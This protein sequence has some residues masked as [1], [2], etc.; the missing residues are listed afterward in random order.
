MPQDPVLQL[1]E[2]HAEEILQ[3]GRRERV[4]PSLRKTLKVL[5]RYPRTVCVIMGGGVIACVFYWLIAPREYEARSTVALRT[6]RVN[7]LHL[8]GGDEGAISAASGP[9]QLETLAGVFRS[10]QLA[11]RVILERHL[12]QAWA[13]NGDFAR[14]F[15]DFHPEAVHPSAQGFLLERFQQR[16]MVRTIPR[17]LLMEIRFRSR[18]PMLS[19]E[20][21]NELVHAYQQEASEARVQATTQAVKQLQDQLGALKQRMESDGGRVEAFQRQHGIVVPTANGPSGQTNEAGQLPGVQRIRDAERDLAVAT[22]ERIER[23]AEFQAASRG[24]PELVLAANPRLQAQGGNLAGA[25]YQRIHAREGDLQQEMAQLTLEH[26][27]NFPRIVEIRRLLQDLAQQRSAEDA[28]VVESLRRA[29]DEALDRERLARKNLEQRVSEGQPENEAAAQLERM[30]READT[31]QELYLRTESKLQ[32]ASLV[33]GVHGSEI[34]VVDAARVPTRPTWP[35][36]PL[37]LSVAI[38]AST[39][40]AVTVVLVMERLGRLRASSAVLLLIVFISAWRGSAQAPTPNNSGLPSGVARLP[41][42]SD[43]RSN[44]NAKEAPPVWGGGALSGSQAV[45]AT[46]NRTPFPAPIAAGDSLEVSEFH[47]P[48]FR[49]SVRVSA[50]GN[51]NLPL[52]GE[53]AIQGMDEAGAAR[54]IGAALV[55]KGMLLH[56]QVFVLITGYVGQDVSV[57]GEVVRPGIY[58]YTAH[59]RLLDLI[60]AA[61]GL[62]ATAGS[63][64]DVYHRQ[65]PDTAH[66]VKLSASGASGDPESSNPELLPGDT[67]R[68]TRAGLVYVLGDVI[69]PGGFAI[70]PRQAVTVLEALSLA[71]GPSQNAAAQKALVIHEQAGGR[72]VETLNLKRMLRGQD[73]DLPLHERDIV[74]VP[75]ST[76]KNLWN[77]TMESVVQSVAGV[78]I[79]SGLVY[80]QRY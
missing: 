68:V 27:P 48:E 57:L 72:T 28:R 11:W 42:S 22:S 4:A 35:N 49:S 75:D 32:E 34:W 19:A 25:A 58:P 65:D 38:F 63:V 53:I 44:P 39:W 78:A 26:G 56:P 12:Y 52:I 54:A 40:V 17:T 10:D 3:A 2:L 76:A 33:A 62:N 29:W 20:V 51:V 41:Q 69:R 71:W 13:F 36:L 59:H 80:S 15:P 60:A 70:G 5:L 16:L 7:A 24:D 50:A 30:Q 37:L 77:R 66:S 45:S 46:A 9:P 73:P 21:V 14:R 1:P 64:V 18:D 8:G 31:T 55:E 23:E 74:F 6:G 47:T 61:S 67:V 43:N 79:Y